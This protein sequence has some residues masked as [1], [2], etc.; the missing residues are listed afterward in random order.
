MRIADIGCG[1]G[2]TTFYLNRLVQPGGKTVGVDMSANRIEYARQKYGDK[3][4]EY[5]INDIRQPREVHD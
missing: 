4:I 1:A 3:N 2:K 5:V